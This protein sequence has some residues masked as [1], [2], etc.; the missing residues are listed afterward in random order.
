MLS[1]ILR[2][3][4][5]ERL[6][7]I[8]TSQGMGQLLGVPSIESSTGQHQAEAVYEALVDWAMEKN[9][10]ALCCD[11]TSSNTGRIKGACILLAVSYTHLTLPTIYSV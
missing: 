1:G 8:V 3:S 4:S 6:A 10:K 2:N 7:V 11:S 5:S 9:I